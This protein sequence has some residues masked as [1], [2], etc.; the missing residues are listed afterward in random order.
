MN[1]SPIKP[2]EII[3]AS[4]VEISKKKKLDIEYQLNERREYIR[5]ICDNHFVRAAATKLISL[6]G[7]DVLVVDKMSALRQNN[8]SWVSHFT[9]YRYILHSQLYFPIHTRT[10]FFYGTIFE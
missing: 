1:A 3:N 10:R 7:Q 2:V 4:P 6:N 5:K 8:P 9:C